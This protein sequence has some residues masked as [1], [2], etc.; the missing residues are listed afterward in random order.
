MA[1]RM[2]VLLGL[3]A[4]TALAIP[5]TSAQAAA[6]LCFGK[7]ATI[8]GTAGP[9][10]LVGQSGI[11]DV[12]YAGDGNDSV[13][14]GDFYSEDSVPGAAP[15][16]LC[17]GP[18]DDTVYGGPGNDKINGGDGNDHVDGRLGADLV[19]GN[20]GDD[21]VNDQSFA[22]MDGANDVLKGGTGNDLLTTGWGIDKAY[23]EAGNDTIIDLE[24]S[25][26]YLYGGPG[27]D[28]FESYWSSFNGAYC[29]GSKDFLDGSDGIDRAK[30][31]RAD[32]V[33]HV[34]SLQRITAAY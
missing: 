26:S 21:R 6:P 7:P 15:D 10:N 9:D 28:T 20:V 11:S 18:G 33:L 17:G 32:S 3:T 12:I 16:L 14:G 19:Q 13:L 24:C 2:C 34:E 1:R 30:A 22:D 31:S 29:A 5:S 8:V 25:T 23:G 4:L 27:A